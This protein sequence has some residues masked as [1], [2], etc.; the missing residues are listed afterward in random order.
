MSVIHTYF[1]W[2]LCVKET[3]KFMMFTNVRIRRTCRKKVEM[4]YFISLILQR[5]EPT[6]SRLLSLSS[7][8]WAT[9]TVYIFWRKSDP[10][11]YLFTKMW[12][13]CSHKWAAL[14]YICAFYSLMCTVHTFQN[15]NV[16]IMF[17]FKSKMHNMK[18]KCEHFT[19]I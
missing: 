17:T 10:Y 14:I 5:S 9:S 6:T 18:K 15:F 7:S 19:H 13:L 16:N 12:V 4:Y 3:L 11:T 8:N 1:S 2:T